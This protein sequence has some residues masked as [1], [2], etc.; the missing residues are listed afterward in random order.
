VASPTNSLTVR[1]AR[2][3]SGRQ[4]FILALLLPAFLLIT[5][6][7]SP[8]LMALPLLWA[9]RK[10]G[11]GRFVPP[12]PLNS[13][14]LLLLV[15]VLVSVLVTYDIAFSLAKIAGV[16]FG[17][18]LFYAV[19]DWA[20]RSPRNLWLG[21]AALIVAG[22]GVVALGLVGV[23]WQ[24]K[25]PFLGGLL[26]FL[27]ERMLAV[28]GSSQ[29]I[30]RN[31]V[32]GVLLWIAPLS[33][34]LALG[35]SL[36][37]LAMAAVSE[38]ARRP[39]LIV[40][41]WVA[42]LIQCGTVILTQ[43][44]AGLA[45]LG[46]SLFLTLVLLSG[47]FRRRFVL[48]LTLALLAAT[49]V[50]WQMGTER[51]GEVLFFQAGIDATDSAFN[52]LEGRREIWSRALYGIQDFPFTGMGMN[53]FRQVVHVLYPLF[54][55]PPDADIAHAHNHLL[56]AALDLGLPG[57]VAYLALWLCAAG[58]LWQ[59]WRREH[60]VQGRVLV[61]GF[62]ASLLAYFV[63]GMV[64]AVALGARPGFLFWLLLG[65][66]AGQYALVVD[67]AAGEGDV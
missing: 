41:L 27:P 17:V 56:Q 21:V 14:L 59:S 43:S 65:L 26:P 18:A 49:L 48:L 13:T 36:R 54:L 8:L 66:I 12:T 15:M 32:A 31:E 51:V 11:C 37:R 23:D 58:M 35:F 46:A 24:I 67:A 10:V 7:R 47:R 19:V 61:A 60:M 44:R 30:N 64:D 2:G 63:Y 57:L 6:A 38:A 28:P 5:P 16:L 45:G 40:A 50:V 34:A 9:L 4:W 3:I 29:G 42:A 25:L 22:F 62:A 55:I 39:L 53:T 20:R 52:S 1:L 33:L